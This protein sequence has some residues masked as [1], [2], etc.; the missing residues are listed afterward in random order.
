VLRVLRD[1]KRVEGKILA[2]RA[3]TPAGKIPQ[4]FFP[5]TPVFPEHPERFNVFKWL[6]EHTP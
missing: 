1:K 3:K 4:R 5:N 6:E 2:T